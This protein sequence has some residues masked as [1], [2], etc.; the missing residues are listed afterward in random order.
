YTPNLSRV[1]PFGCSRSTVLPLRRR[2][3]RGRKLPLEAGASS[4][5]TKGS[6]PRWGRRGALAIFILRA[7]PAGRFGNFGFLR[8]GYRAWI[9]LAETGLMPI[10]ISC[11]AF[12]GL[13]QPDNLLRCETPADRAQILAQLLLIARADDES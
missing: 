8:R 9:A 11:R 7:A 1:E 2:H 10:G 5:S 13:V 4:L 12:A 3:S 6:C